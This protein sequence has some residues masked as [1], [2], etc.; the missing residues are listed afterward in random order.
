M[1]RR[2]AGS[3]IDVVNPFLCHQ[4][5]AMLSVWDSVVCLCMPNQLYI[6]AWWITLT[7][8]YRLLLVTWPSGLPQETSWS[9][10]SAEHLPAI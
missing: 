10:M 1:R 6:H 7:A 5:S 2:W 3:N 4:R 9:L 8:S